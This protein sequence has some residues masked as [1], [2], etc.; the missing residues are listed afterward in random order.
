MFHDRIKY[1]EQ[2]WGNQFEIFWEMRKDCLPK[3]LRLEDNP[4]DPGLVK[5]KQNHYLTTGQ[6]IMMENE[7]DCFKNDFNSS[8]GVERFFS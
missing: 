2:E 4:D 3:H 5:E 1:A 6:V 7:W 8:K